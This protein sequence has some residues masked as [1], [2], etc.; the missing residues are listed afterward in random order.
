MFRDVKTCCTCTIST[1]QLFTYSFYIL[2]VVMLQ[3]LF[4][5]MQRVS[6]ATNKNHYRILSQSAK[7]REEGSGP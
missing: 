3:A 1:W 2:H 7:D 5:W 6:T 4:D